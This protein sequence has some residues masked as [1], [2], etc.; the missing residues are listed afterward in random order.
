MN[1]NTE[2]HFLYYLKGLGCISVTFA[3]CPFPGLVGILV[4]GYARFAVPMFFMV[5]GYYL[6]TGSGKA[7]TWSDLMRD[8]CKKAGRMLGMGLALY[9]LW[10]PLQLLVTS[11]SIAVVKEWF[12]NLFH[13]RS[14]FS[15]V[16]LNDM[17]SIGGHLWYLASLLYCY[18]FLWIIGP[19]WLKER[20]W[21]PVPILLMGHMILRAIADFHGIQEV[22][23]IPVYIILRNWLMMG[24]PFFMTGVLIRRNQQQILEL[25]SEKAVKILFWAGVLLSGAEFLLTYFHIGTDK[26]LYPGIVLMVVS[27]FLYAVR[28]PEKKGIPVVGVVGKRYLLPIYLIHL[29][30]IEGMQIIYYYLR[31]IDAAWYPWV[32]PVINSILSICGAVIWSNCWSRL[33]LG[34]KRKRGEK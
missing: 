14:L 19:R 29:A 7:P 8:R 31:I 2:N 32:A 25:I 1:K 18:L 13:P 26:E 12:L 9:G 16:V 21:I 30:V 28:N 33:T 15:M 5:S 11:G 22:F 20:A 4:N 24:V 23:G 34:W 27:M 10:R 6:L 3:H 17:T